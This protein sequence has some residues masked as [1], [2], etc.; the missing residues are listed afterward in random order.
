MAMAT[1]Q[2]V[3][4]PDLTKSSVDIVCAYISRNHVVAGD[5]PNLIMNVQAA[6]HSLSRSTVGTPAADLVPAVSV[7]K[8]ISPD[9]ITCLDCGQSFKSLRRHIS[10]AHAMIPETYRVRWGLP[11]DYPMVSENYSAK[12]SQLAKDLGL[13]RT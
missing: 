1:Q 9:R 11:V 3:S 2:T 13:R 6:L 5:L 10:A 8:S 12:R 7:A 4:P